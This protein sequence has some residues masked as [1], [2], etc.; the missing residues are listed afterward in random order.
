MQSKHNQE[1]L[2]SGLFHCSAFQVQIMLIAS[3]LISYDDGLQK[4]ESWSHVSVKS[5]AV[6]HHVSFCSSDN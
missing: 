1:H 2:D 3:A 6:C 4:V 5:C